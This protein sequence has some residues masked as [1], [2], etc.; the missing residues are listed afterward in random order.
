MLLFQ[1]LTERHDC[2]AHIFLR[3]KVDFIFPNR[4]KLWRKLPNTHPMR[5]LARFFET[6]PVSLDISPF[7]YIPIIVS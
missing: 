5:R 7:E 1:D 4:E 3:L 2:P 6:L